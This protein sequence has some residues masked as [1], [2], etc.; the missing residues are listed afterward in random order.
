MPTAIRRLALA[1]LIACG[2][3]FGQAIVSSIVGRVADSS[4]AGVPGA[5][6]TVTNTE[7]GISVQTTT[8]SEGTYSV[9]G[10]LSGTYNVNV[11]KSG[12]QSYTA[13]G[14]TL[15]SS[16]IARVDV[17]LSLSG[18][19]QTVSVVER[20]PMI[21][22][23][24]MTI[25]TSVT[26]QQLEELPTSVQTIDAFIALAP[27][28]QAYG[29]AG[30][31][32]IGGGRNWGSVNFTLNGVEVNDP[33]NSGG[34]LVQ[35]WK[36]GTNALLVLPPPSAVQ[37]LN[38]QSGG[39]TAQYRGKST[40]TIVTKGGTNL[41]HGG[42][43]ENFQNSD[44]N[45]NDFTLNAAGNS[46]RPAEHLNQYGGNIGGPIKREKA[47]FF[48]D[49]SGFRRA[50]EIASQ[51]RLPSAAMR[52]GD[53]SA[54]CTGQGG[55]FANGICSNG[56]N[57]LYN[58]FSGNP[59]P[60][61]QIPGSMITPQSQK[62]LTYLPLPTVA[63]SP[64]LPNG[65]FNYISTVGQQSRIGAWDLRMDYNVS[66]KDRL[67]GVFARRVADPLGVAGAGYPSN[68]GSRVNLYKETSAT[69]S[70]THT[71][72][73]ST[74]NEFRASWGNYST[75]FA[76][77]NLDFDTKSLWPQ[78]P[79][80]PFKGLPTITA[81]GYTGLWY[82]YGSG[83]VTPRLD[84]EL[85]DDFT[86]IHGKHTIQAG[87]DETGYKMFNRADA[88]GALPGAFGFTG[89]WTGNS[90][91]PNLPHSNGNSFADFLLGTANSSQTSATGA[92]GPGWTYSRY[93]GFYAQDTWQ[94]TPRL[95]IIYGLRYEYQSPWRFRTPQI[96]SIDLRNGKL[97]LPENSA[98]PTIP[99]G[100]QANLFAAYPF[101]TTQS[102][103]V[104]L[105]YDR[106]D[107][108]NFAPRIGFA[109]RPFNDQRTVI[110]GGYGVYY[111]FQPDLVGSA[112]EGFNPPWAFG[113]TQ[114]FT[115]K[116]PGKP[117][118]AF[119]PDIVFSN[120]F[121]GVN[122]GSN[123]TPNPTLW[124]FQWDFQNAMVQEWNF[125]IEH[126]LGNLALRASYLGDQTHHIPANAADLNRPLVQQP[127]VPIQNQRPYQP[128]GTIQSYLSLGKQSFNQLQLGAQMRFSRGLSFQAQYQ[129]TRSLDNI[130]NS[131]G[132]DNPGSWNLSYGNTPGVRRHWLVYNYIYELPFGNNAHGLIKA[133]AGGW[134]I[135]GISTYGTGTPFSVTY[136]QTGTGIVGWSG[137]RADQLSG[138]SF[139]NKQSG[140]D[141][142]SGVQWFNTT[143]FAPPAKWTWGNSARNMLWGPGLWNWDISGSKSF[144]L[145]ERFRLQVRSD[146][147][148]AFNH[149]NLS[150]PNAS[151]PDTRDGGTPN[152]TSGKITSGSGSRIVQLGLK[153]SF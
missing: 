43:Y 61:N 131:G 20:A 112:R 21:Q 108:N 102:I 140:H 51:L 15:H 18:M 132:P 147:L 12:F 24:S 76:G 57:Q 152:P 34:V 70:E 149:F 36:S 23:D 28:V 30:N 153:L 143:A 151:I 82:D 95:T 19:K 110:R 63:N 142:K 81:S 7:T 104:P 139:Y 27:G 66:T 45:A 35:N 118:T 6:I 101:E 1:G 33:G 115:T 73:P 50:Y 46:H 78:M 40:V 22:T 65:V 56:N 123:V 93:W 60:N 144:A 26:T 148:D 53:F 67:F 88:A 89:T 59:F 134:Q 55:S 5:Q 74:L 133:L 97:V 77:I 92:W 125:T 137:T 2:V 146:F 128:W 127:N 10:L 136:A 32:P 47:F 111:N 119:M 98:T 124:Y 113:I 72:S 44:L 121:P 64:G 37:E 41:F 14:I 116:L 49:Y 38:V 3:V 122:A 103:G 130:D 90:S 29:G 42:L 126:Q 80:S 150:N 117:A 135:S 86:H 52:S 109:F 25:G 16:E 4:G 83:P 31:P 68:Y 13:A 145:R 69:L 138:V 11:E 91:W 85:A 105:F 62:L 106:G 17:P 96:T 39:M 75:K 129:F 79:D 100:A 9:P 48:F 114:S 54:L 84:V 94:A 107:K 87:A 141:I 71:F 8:G 58:P 99:A 120:P